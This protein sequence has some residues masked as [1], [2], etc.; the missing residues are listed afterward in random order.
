MLSIFKE[1]ILWESFIHALFNYS[2][3]A[4]LGI[5]N[6]AGLRL[7][8][9]F[10]PSFIHL[11]LW[12]SFFIVIFIL[13][14]FTTFLCYLLWILLYL[15][16]YHSIAIFYVL[17]HVNSSGL[18]RHHQSCSCISLIFLIVLDYLSSLFC[19]SFFGSTSNIVS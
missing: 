8:F 1:L 4:S 19:S 5:F 11:L 7:S 14:F 18:R 12:E 16:L 2:L 9:F 10:M 6:L 17:Y 3:W 15:S 13:L